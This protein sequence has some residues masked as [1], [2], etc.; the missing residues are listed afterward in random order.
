MPGG[1]QY[2]GPPLVDCFEVSGLK[3]VPFGGP[4]TLELAEVHKPGN[5]HS[6]VAAAAAVA[7]G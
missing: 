6:H 7:A 1:A 3:F 5:S 4:N 2:G